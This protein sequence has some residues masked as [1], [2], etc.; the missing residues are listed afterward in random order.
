MRTIAVSWLVEVACEY[1]LHQETLFLSTMLLDNFL[2]VAKVCRLGP[3]SPLSSTSS[4]SLPNVRLGED[5]LLTLLANIP[6]LAKD[7]CRTSFCCCKPI[8]MSVGQ[9]L[10]SFQ[11][12][13]AGQTV[14]QQWSAPTQQCA[15]STS[16][17]LQ[18]H[19]G[20]DV[21]KSCWTCM[22]H[23]L[24]APV[25][26]QTCPCWTWV[27]GPHAQQPHAFNSAGDDTHGR[28]AW[29]FTLSPITPFSPRTGPCH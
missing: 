9:L 16:T 21:S 23:M 1:G 28:L 15:W 11:R 8:T 24:Q 13:Q 26:H 19:E 2:G 10:S 5:V 25:K 20:A 3:P 17:S 12:S 18:Q 6:L 4:L 7:T 27:A 22:Q 29:S 14:K